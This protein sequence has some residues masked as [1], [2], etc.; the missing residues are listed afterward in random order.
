[1]TSVETRLTDVGA[2]VGSYAEYYDRTGLFPQAGIDAVHAAGLL[3][4]TV[5]RRHGGKEIG[6]EET[7][8]ILYALGRGDP[9]V[10][11]ISA[12]TMFVHAAEARAPKWPAEL[13]ARIVAESAG[14][15]TLLNAARVEPDLGSP[16]R[17]GLPATTARRTPSGWAISGTKRFVT[18]AHGLSYFLVWARTDDGRVGTFVVDASSDGIEIVDNWNMLGLRAS[19]SVDVHFSGV[20]VP[21][22]DV[23]DLVDASFGAQDN[24]AAARLNTGLVALYL[25]VGRAA[26]EEFHRFAHERVPANLGRPLATTDRFRD[27]AGEI[28]LLLTGAETLLFGAVADPDTAPTALLGARVLAVRHLT[29]AVGLAVK[30]IGNPGL[31]QDNP[32]QRHFRNVQSA[33]VH[34]PQEDT[35]IAII[36]ASA[37]KSKGHP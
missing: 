18:G 12:M 1:M 23:I 29:S 15:P 30:S 37:L 35:S 21:V 34:A 25:G 6:P 22:G 31:S 7:A 27:L 4:S 32:L 36:G 9:S 17:G 13:Y 14:A 24:S 19:G 3:T 8:R 20:E 16:A 2:A 10:A 26:Q 11:L 28:E 33:S 5:A